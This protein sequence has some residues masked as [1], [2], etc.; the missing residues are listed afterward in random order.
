MNTDNLEK[1]KYNTY[2]QNGGDGILEEVFK[3]LGLDEFKLNKYF[4]LTYTAKDIN[5]SKS[6]KINFVLSE[7][8]DI[9]YEEYIKQINA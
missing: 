1:Y 8:D 7:V 9:I 2:S 3:R 5:F 6:K 4:I